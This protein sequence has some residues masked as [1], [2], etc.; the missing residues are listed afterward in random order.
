MNS[1]PN[2][3]GRTL[4]DSQCRGRELSML[5]GRTAER[6]RLAAILVA[7][8]VGYSRL[9]AEYETRT[10]AEVRALRG[11]VLEPAFAV[12]GGRLFKAMGDAFFAEF[13]SAV[14]AVSCAVEVQRRLLAEGLARPGLALRIGVA[15]GDVVVE[16]DGDLL[17]D[18][19][20]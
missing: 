18:G 19:V 12:H 14:E 5:T 10:L 11:Q 3:P 4:P 13:P 7:D 6:R 20:N 9:V 16:G 1:E 15:L 8:V 17:G 2:L